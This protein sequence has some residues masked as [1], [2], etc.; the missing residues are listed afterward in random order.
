[1]F[2]DEALLKSVYLFR[3][4]FSKHIKHHDV[5]MAEVNLVAL[6]FAIKEEQMQLKRKKRFKYVH[7][8]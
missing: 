5:W 3:Y 8:K 2:W 6:N 7:A 1:M 4:R